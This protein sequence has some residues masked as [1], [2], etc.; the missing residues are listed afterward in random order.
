[1]NYQNMREE[2]EW[3]RERKKNIKK[4]N[5]SNRNSTRGRGATNEEKQSSRHKKQQQQKKIKNKKKAM[6]TTTK[7]PA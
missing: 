4:G 6:T 3:T 7:A 2:Q 5:R 1:M